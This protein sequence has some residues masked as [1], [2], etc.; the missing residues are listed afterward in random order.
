MKE[1]IFAYLVAAAGAFLVA[2]ALSSCTENARARHWGGTQNIKVPCGH[3]AINHTWKNNDLWYSTRPFREGEVPETTTF[4]EKSS[5]GN[6][7][8]KIVFKECRK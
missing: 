5:F 4:R 6:M 7:E 1:K 3:K 8:G 2:F